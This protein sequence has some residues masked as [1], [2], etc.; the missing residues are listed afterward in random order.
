M[1]GRCAYF[2]T[3][4]LFPPPLPLF[5]SGS[6]HHT[7]HL[8]MPTNDTSRG[9]YKFKYSFGGDLSQVASKTAVLKSEINDA[10]SEFFQAKMKE[11]NDEGFQNI[12]GYK[13]LVEQINQMMNFLKIHRKFVNKIPEIT[14]SITKSKEAE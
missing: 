11:L 1:L 2:C 13:I 14:R 9:R 6:A 5:T 12:K 8:L 3:N 10:T 7:S 4:L